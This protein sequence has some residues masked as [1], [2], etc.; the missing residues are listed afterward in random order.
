MTTLADLADYTYGDSVS[1]A[2]SKK[3]RS[4]A[5]SND[6]RPSHFQRINPRS[7]TYVRRGTA[8][9]RVLLPWAGSSAGLAAGA[10]LGAKVGGQAGAGIGGALGGAG[11]G[12]LG[13]MRNVKS[14]DTK[15][16][17]RKTGRKMKQKAQIPYIGAMNLY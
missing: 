15:A 10:V 1:K 17:H 11:G 3:E 12:T 14:G 16:F 13:Y 2:R 6:Y 5:R 7:R 8:A 9:Q 4:L